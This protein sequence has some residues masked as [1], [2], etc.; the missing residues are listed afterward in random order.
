MRI[1]LTGAT[2]ALGQGLLPA[3]RAHEIVVLPRA[4]EGRT[5]AGEAGAVLHL[6]G[7]KYDSGGSPAEF[8]R[9]NAELTERLLARL[10]SSGFAKPPHFVF[11]SSMYVY[12]ERSEAPLS[13][14]T[15][16]RPQTPYGLSKLSAEKMIAETCARL[17]MPFT[18]L[19]L[20]TV[21]GTSGDVLSRMESRF[22]LL[23]PFVVGDGGQKRSLLSIENLR[24][25]V[26][27]ALGN[28]RWQG[29]TVNV[30]DPRP[31]TMLEVVGRAAGVRRVRR[32]PPGLARLASGFGGW[33]DQLRRLSESFSLDVTRLL[34]LNPGP[35][36][37]LTAARG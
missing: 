32:V 6:A 7:K 4:L 20:A 8:A 25:V 27:A 34:S 5:P 19:R 35:L 36:E 33:G 26:L 22:R 18:I 23:P 15:Q 3:L 24:R 21:Y 2:G 11:F 28:P 17:K 37:I 1:L 16:P 12:G 30:A 10:E 14:Q 13:E 29:L 31:Y 9:A